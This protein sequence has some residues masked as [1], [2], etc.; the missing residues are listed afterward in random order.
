ML[1]RAICSVLPVGTNARAKAQSSALRLNIKRSSE[2]RV[3][4]IG[5]VTMARGRWFVNEIARTF[6]TSERAP[7][8]GPHHRAGV[9][10]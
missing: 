9:V 6:A 5:D 3:E 1:I 4:H 8:N 10:S 7:T 2:L